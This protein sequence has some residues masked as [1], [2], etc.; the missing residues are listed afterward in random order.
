MMN[1]TSG[2]SAA[3]NAATS[4]RLGLETPTLKVITSRVGEPSATGVS[5]PTKKGTTSSPPTTAEPRV[6]QAA[7]LQGPARATRPST[8]RTTAAWGRKLATPSRIHDCDPRNA[9]SETADRVT[10][11]IPARAPIRSPRPP[12]RNPG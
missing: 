12:V 10:P 7:S 8:S 5:D 11:A 6:I 1:A 3:M 4:A 9:A 2:S